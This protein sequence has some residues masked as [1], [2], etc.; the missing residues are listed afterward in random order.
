MK[1]PHLISI[2]APHFSAGVVLE[3]DVVV[4]AAPIIG[5][6][7]GWTSVEVSRYAAKKGWTIRETGEEED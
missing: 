1:K 5:Y 2:D 3:K 6:M 4:R 7:K